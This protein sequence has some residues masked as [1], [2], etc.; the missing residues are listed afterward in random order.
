MASLVGSLFHTTFAAISFAGAGYFFKAFDK[1]GYEAEIK[2]HNKALEDLQKAKETF[3]QNEVKQHDRIQQ[4]RQQLVDAKNDIVTT[5]KALDQLR[6]VQSIQYN[7]KTFN[8]EPQLNDFY[9]PSDEMKEYQY[10]AIG[11]IGVGSG[12]LLRKII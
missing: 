1:N 5:D 9:H 4:L 12:Y 2:R 7:G 10:I 6:Q 11:V 8:R 3:Y